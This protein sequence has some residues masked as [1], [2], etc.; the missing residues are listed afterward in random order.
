M[1]SVRWIWTPFAELSL[2][3]LY[4]ALLLRQAVFVVEQDCPYLDADGDDPRCH[5]LLGYSAAGLDAYLRVYPPGDTRDEIV[6]GR[7]VTHQR[8]RRQ[9]LGRR[10]MA[11]GQ[12]RAFAAWGEGP[13]WLSAQ[14]YLLSFYQSLGYRVVGPGYDEDGIPHFPMRRP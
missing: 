12:A 7:V 1:S 2:V 11:E 8:V 6:I 13:I 4:D 5:H 14:A 3:Q 10:L 9:G